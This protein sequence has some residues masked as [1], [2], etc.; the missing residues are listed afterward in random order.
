MADRKDEATAKDNNTANKEIWTTRRTIILAIIVVVIVGVTAGIAIYRDRIAP[1]NTVIV[2]VNDK[3]FDMRYFLKRLNYSGER[4]FEMLSTLTEE[5]VLRQ[6]APNPPYNIEVT[7]DE[8]DDLARDFARGSADSIDENVFN[9]WYRQQLNESGFSDEEFR[10][11]LLT[12][13][14][15]H[16]MHEY[17]G[18]RLPTVAEHVFVNLIVV[19]DF[20]TARKVREKLD[21]G[22]DFSDLARE[23]SIDPGLKEN[24]GKSGWFPRGVL[25]AVFDSEAFELEIGEYSEPLY[26][27]DDSAVIM[28]ISDRAEAKKIDEES[29]EILKSKVLDEWLLAEQKKHDV[30][31]H[32]FAGGGYDSETDAWVSWQLMRMQRGQQ[33]EQQESQAG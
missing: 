6:V 9:E 30:D 8:I 1:F 16:E 13:L 32:G 2:R 5:E 31:F 29:M 19:K 28:M 23:Y 27:D 33:G 15:G 25:D 24:G 18:E 21:N 11:L 14:L 3:E 17:L 12:T 20:E 4:S 22:E 26:L 7:E 10:E